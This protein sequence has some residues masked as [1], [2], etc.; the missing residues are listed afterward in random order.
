MKD[1]VLEYIWNEPDYIAN[2]MVPGS[3]ILLAYKKEASSVEK[4]DYELVEGNKLKTYVAQAPK[5]PNWNRTN[6]GPVYLGVGGHIILNVTN[7][8]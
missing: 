3:E 7:Y 8:T 2:T 1:Q 6:G 5:L 4:K